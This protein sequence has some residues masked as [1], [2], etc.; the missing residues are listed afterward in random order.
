MTVTT[1]RRVASPGDLVLPGD[2]SGPL[3]ELE[4]PDLEPTGRAVVCLLPPDG[5]GPVRLASPPWEFRECENGALEITDAKAT[6]P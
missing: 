6:L 2:Y 5:S 3:T 1:G 4:G